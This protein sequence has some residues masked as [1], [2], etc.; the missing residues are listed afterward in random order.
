MIW[1]NIKLHSLNFTKE[2]KLQR[3]KLKM[4]LQMLKLQ[5]EIKNKEIICLVQKKKIHGI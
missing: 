5:K 4:D 2:F 1:I 3:M